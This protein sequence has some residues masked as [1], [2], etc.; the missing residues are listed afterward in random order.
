MISLRLRAA[1][2]VV[3][4]DIFFRR[5]I[6]AMINFSRRAQVLH[7][8]LD[9]VTRSSYRQLSLITDHHHFLPPFF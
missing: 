4:S 5:N 8:V 3:T 9:G 2:L 6:D 7:G 1:M